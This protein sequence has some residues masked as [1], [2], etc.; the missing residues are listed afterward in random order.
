MSKINFGFGENE[1]FK[2]NYETNMA[3]DDGFIKKKIDHDEM[4]TKSRPKLKK[5]EEIVLRLIKETL[6]NS[7]AQALLEN[8]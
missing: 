4:T 7:A 6:Y 8:V 1:S 2:T 3:M 5:E